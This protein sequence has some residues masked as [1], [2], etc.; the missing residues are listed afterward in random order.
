MKGF[1]DYAKQYLDRFYKA[2]RL[3]FCPDNDDGGD[4]A[5]ERWFREYPQ[6]LELRA[7]GGKDL[8]DA[9]R[10]ALSGGDAWRVVDWLKY[11][12]ALC[13]DHSEIGLDL[14]AKECQ[15]QW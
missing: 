11:A 9:E 10:S 12:K 2:G 6:A 13:E 4:A 15:K 7:Y 14:E 8:G 3:V 1:S 5:L